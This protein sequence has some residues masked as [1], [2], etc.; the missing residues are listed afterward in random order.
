MVRFLWSVFTARR[1][2]FARTVC[3]VVVCLSVCLSR[4]VLYQNLGTR[5][6]RHMIARGLEVSFVKYLREIR[7][8]SY[9]TGTKNAGGVG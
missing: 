5:K 7:S 6:Q 4:P 2:A 3:V 8:G 9:L 1:Y